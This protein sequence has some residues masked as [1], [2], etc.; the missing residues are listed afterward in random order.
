[1]RMLRLVLLLVRGT[2]D[3]VTVGNRRV[4]DCSSSMEGTRV[5]LM[6]GLMLEGSSRA[7]TLMS[8]RIGSVMMVERIVM[9]MERI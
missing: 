6:L 2:V 9:M 7:F 5:L 3:R 1:M 4:A 8:T